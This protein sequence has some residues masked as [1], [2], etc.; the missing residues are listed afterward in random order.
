MAAHDV[1]H[2]TTD[3][4]RVMVVDAS[5]MVR[6]LIGDM[7]QRDLPGVEVIGCGGL[8]EARAAL[9][10]GPVDLVTTSLVLM[11]GDGLQ[12]ARQ[13]R[14]SAGQRYVPVIVVSGDAQAHLEARRFTEDVT[15]YFDKADGYP[16]LAAFIRG[17][18]HPEPIP[19]ARVLYVE[20][21]I[22]VAVATRRMLQAHDISVIHMSRG[23]DA[24]AYLNEHLGQDDI[25]ADLLLTDVTLDGAVSGLDLLRSVRNDFGYGKRRMPV[26]VMTGDGNRDK[27]SNLLREGANDLV[28][29]PIE[30]R[31]LI[32]KTVFQLRMAKLPEQPSLE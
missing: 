10:E 13:V 16:A 15:D 12:V 2:L 21:S 27:Q 3:T 14:S 31:L 18:V 17:Y 28:L 8:A 32:T 1:R 6:R 22:T 23:D 25:G 5:K 4:P 30:E 29:K 19:D 11:D 20:D 9:E 26:L 7:L 24:L